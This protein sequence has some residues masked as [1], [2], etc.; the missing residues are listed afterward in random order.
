MH[1]GAGGKQ[2][3]AP[4]QIRNKKAAT[5]WS[6]DVID[7]LSA[8]IAKQVPREKGQLRGDGGECQVY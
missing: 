5:S 4:R 6:R 7:S 8:S 1:S 2:R 3:R